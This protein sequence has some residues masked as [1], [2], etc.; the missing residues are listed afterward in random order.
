[1]VGCLWLVRQNGVEPRFDIDLDYG[2][3]LED[4]FHGILTGELRVE[5]KRN[6]YAT[7]TGNIAVELYCRGK[8]S[9]F[10]VSQAKY[11]YFHIDEY[12]SG[13]LISKER[14]NELMIK[15][16]SNITIGGDDQRSLMILI[17]IVEVLK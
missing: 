5:V 4:K 9:G 11:W 8:P 15:F 14:L 3:E 10:L 17:P 12:D 2:L 7:R 16:R 13:L 6:R 1:M